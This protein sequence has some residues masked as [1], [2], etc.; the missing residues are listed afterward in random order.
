MPTACYNKVGRVISNIIHKKMTKKEFIEI[1]GEN[2]EDM[3]GGDWENDI[4][5][6]DS[7]DL[8]TMP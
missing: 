6:I 4:S 8:S 2:P 1:F 7:E 5:K 3:F